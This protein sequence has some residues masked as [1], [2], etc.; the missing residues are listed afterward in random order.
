MTRRAQLDIP[1]S[2]L[3]RV[4]N[5]PDDVEIVGIFVMP[6][7]FLTLRLH[8]TGVGLPERCEQLDEGEIMSL[9]GGLSGETKLTNA[10]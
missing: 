9:D 5:L 3:R 6:D 7:R 10:G 4:L 1:A 2:Y 8:L